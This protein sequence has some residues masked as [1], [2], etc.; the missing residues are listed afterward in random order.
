MIAIYCRA[1]HGARGTLCAECQDLLDYAQSRLDRCPFGDR[2]PTCGRCPTHCYKP[3]MRIRVKE[4][5]RLAGPRMFY[6][7]PIL[8]LLHVFEAL[9]SQKPAAKK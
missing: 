5:M 6:R 4:V 2:K 1:R 7:H 8:A 3:A 9:R